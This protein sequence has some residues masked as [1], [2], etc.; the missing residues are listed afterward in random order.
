MRQTCRLGTERE[1]PRQPPW[2]LMTAPH[3]KRVAR[4]EAAFP[5]NQREQE[6]ELKQEQ[7]QELKQEQEQE[8]QLEACFWLAV[9]FEV[10]QAQT[11]PEPSIKSERTLCGGVYP[12]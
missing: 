9:L 4:F 10:G 6:Q 11:F 7:E 2:Y 5:K 8:Q 3:P 1:M 12:A